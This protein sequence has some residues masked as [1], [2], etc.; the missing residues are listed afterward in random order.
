MRPARVILEMPPVRARK[1][2]ALESHVTSGEISVPLMLTASV[3]PCGPCIEGP[4]SMLSYH[5]RPTVELARKSGNEPYGVTTSY[6][7]TN[8]P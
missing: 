2:V 4:F 7:A 3:E 1:V 6:S 8:E 5:S